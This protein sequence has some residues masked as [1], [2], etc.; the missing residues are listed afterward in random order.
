MRG[1]LLED[2]DADPPQPLGPVVLADPARGHPGL[3]Q[4]VGRHG[5]LTAEKLCKNMQRLGNFQNR[6]D[7][8]FFIIGLSKEIENRDFEP[9]S[10]YPKPHIFPEPEPEQGPL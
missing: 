6:A 2:G 4:V 9:G 8:I 3:L 1:R 5:Q 10:G 7:F